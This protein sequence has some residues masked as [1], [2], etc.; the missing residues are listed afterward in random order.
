[1]EG[2]YMLHLFLLFFEVTARNSTEL[3][4]SATCSEMVFR[5]LVGP[6]LPILGGFKLTS[7]LKLEN[8]QTN[9]KKYQL[10]RVPYTPPKFDEWPTNG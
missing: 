3:P 10:R 6:K 9:G 8:L 5:N 2:H 1:M 7:R 4:N